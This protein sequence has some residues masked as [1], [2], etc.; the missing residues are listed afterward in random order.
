MA[1]AVSPA[2]EVSWIKIVITRNASISRSVTPSTL[3]S[4]TTMISPNREDEV[5]LQGKY[6]VDTDLRKKGVFALVPKHG[7][8]HALHSVRGLV[9]EHHHD[10]GN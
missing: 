2:T 8:K 7:T 4:S 10:R 1:D 6:T 5:R 3:S 9:A